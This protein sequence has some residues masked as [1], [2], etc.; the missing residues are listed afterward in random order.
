MND[1]KDKNKNGLPH[2][3]LNLNNNKKGRQCIYGSE[4]YL[5]STAIKMVNEC[6]L[7]IIPKFNSNIYFMEY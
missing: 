2:Y 1:L 5:I 6:V 7:Y 3:H 4:R